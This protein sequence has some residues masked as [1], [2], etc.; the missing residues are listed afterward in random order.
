M[1]TVDSYNVSHWRTV[2]AEW[3]FTKQFLITQLSVFTVVTHHILLKL[4]EFA[5]ECLWSV[6]ASCNGCNV[7]QYCDMCLWTS[8]VKLNR[9]QIGTNTTNFYFILFSSMPFMAGLRQCS[10]LYEF[11]S[12]WNCAHRTFFFLSLYCAEAQYFCCG[13]YDERGKQ[14]TIKCCDG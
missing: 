4:L 1:I 8:I 9:L 6:V 10:Y 5:C 11:I 13:T 2:A 12:N 14:T 3:V 7:R